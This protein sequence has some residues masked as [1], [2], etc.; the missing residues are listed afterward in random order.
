MIRDLELQLAFKFRAYRPLLL[1]ASLAHISPQDPYSVHLAKYRVIRLYLTRDSLP[2]SPSRC[3][4]TGR[5]AQPLGLAAQAKAKSSICSSSCR[6]PTLPL[7]SFPAAAVQPPHS[8]FPSPIVQ[9]PTHTHITHQAS[10][11]HSLASFSPATPQATTQAFRASGA[12]RLQ[13]PTLRP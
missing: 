12:G 11:R 10:P 3:S 1:S 7:P 5:P 8:H 6:T 13:R 4:Y 9:P 2:G